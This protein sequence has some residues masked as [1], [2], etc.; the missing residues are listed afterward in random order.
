MKDYD[1]LYSIKELS[2][3]L[4]E[5]LSTKFLHRQF[6]IARIKK[7]PKISYHKLLHNFDF[8]LTRKL[9]KTAKHKS[10][11]APIN[12]LNGYSKSE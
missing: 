9:N 7:G 6:M 4:S 12:D 3:T 10:V 5:M 11:S 2:I 8:I 1:D